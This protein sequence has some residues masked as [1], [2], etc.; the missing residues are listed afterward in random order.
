MICH[1]LVD[2]TFFAIVYLGLDTKLFT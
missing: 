2:T 1:A